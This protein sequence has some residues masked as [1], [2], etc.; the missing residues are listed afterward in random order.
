[1][2]GVYNFVPNYCP[3]CG[4]ALGLELVNSA[5]AKAVTDYR[6]G[7]SFHCPACNFMYQH[8]TREAI[9]D[10]ADKVPHGDL[11]EYA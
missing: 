3:N 6:A 4:A 2:I 9:L 7:A 1:M 11:R 10:A 8:T 5:G